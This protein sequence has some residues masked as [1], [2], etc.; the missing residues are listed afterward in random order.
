MIVLDSSA[1]YKTICLKRTDL[2]TE[3]FSSA[4]AFFELGNIVWKN[5]HLKPIYS[6]KESSELLSVCEYALNRMRIFYS[7][8]DKIYKIA[9]QC[10]LSFYDAAYLSIAAENEVPLVTLDGALA[11]K[12]STVVKVLTFDQF[13]NKN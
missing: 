8:A 3:R 2:L 12:A 13:L 9:R 11:T 10:K 7:D 1:I 4:L 6:E 5:S